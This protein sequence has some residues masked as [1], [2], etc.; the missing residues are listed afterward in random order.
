MNGLLTDTA[1][2]GVV[3]GILLPLA[4]AVVQQPKW[5][6]RTRTIVGVAAS[7]VVGFA[8]VAANGD[9]TAGLTAPATVAAVV[10]AAQL[11]YTKLWQPAQIAP[12][13]E[14]A[15]SRLFDLGKLLLSR[16]GR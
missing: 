15:T 7:I 1:L 8:T 11:A 10:A 9:L 13:I 16:R 4:T 2:W 3:L 6:K 12:L 14:D 5:S